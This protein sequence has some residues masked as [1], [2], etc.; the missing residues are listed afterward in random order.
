MCSTFVTKAGPITALNVEAK[1]ITVKDLT[2]G[3]PLV[4]KLS[5]DSQMKTLP[6]F[7]AMFSG[8]HGGAPGG[9]PAGGMRGPGGGAP[10]LSQMLERMP[11]T[12]L[13]DLKVGQTIV[14]SSTKG[15]S[16]GQITA[17]ML[18]ANADFLIRM[19]SAQSGGTGRPGA[20][21][22]GGMGAMGGGGMGGLMG[23][24]MGGLDLAR[25]TPS[26]N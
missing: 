11:Q 6:D 13:E 9:A 18:V 20:G 17:I 14:V 4:V 24:R 26:S 25:I 22:P 10:D 2:T 7:A 3:K 8:A 23:G 21:A 5:A 1:E 15:A 16:A 12:R 19:A